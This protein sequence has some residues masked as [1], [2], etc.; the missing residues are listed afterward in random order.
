MF[1][2]TRARPAIAGSRPDP[3]AHS[4][5]SQ[6]LATPGSNNGRGIRGGDYPTTWNRTE[7]PEEHQ[8]V[9]E[10]APE[11]AEEIEES[12]QSGARIAGEIGMGRTGEPEFGWELIF[13]NEDEVVQLS[14]E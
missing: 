11:Q 13:P 14:P 9:Q 4:C 5:N 12:G 2:I 8:I 6:P 3:S 10:P 7:P 1:T